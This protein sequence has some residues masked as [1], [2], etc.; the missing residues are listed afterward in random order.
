MAALCSSVKA[1]P[2]S[3]IV[4]SIARTESA[5]VMSRTAAFALSARLCSMRI[6][7]VFVTRTFSSKRPTTKATCSPLSRM[8]RSSSSATTRVMSS[9]PP[10]MPVPISP[11]AAYMASFSCSMTATVWNFLG[12]VARDEFVRTVE[13][14]AIAQALVDNAFHG[15]AVV[16]AESGGLLAPDVAFVGLHLAET[17][18]GAGV[19]QN[20]HLVFGRHA[21]P[22]EAVVFGVTLRLVENLL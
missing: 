2:L 5:P 13:A 21:V 20:V 4:R 19:P 10:A 22:V 16:P 12:Q 11:R 3:A 6:C 9:G 8:P 1:M 14:L 17:P 18:F 7:A 15:R